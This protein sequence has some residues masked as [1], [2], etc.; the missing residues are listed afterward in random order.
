MTTAALLLGIALGG[1]LDG[2]LLHQILQWHH[3][4]GG[5][6]G[7]LRAQVVWDGLFHLA[8]YLIAVAGL[9][10]LWEARATLVEPGAGRRVWGAAALGFGL[11]HLVDGVVSHFVLGIHRTRL[12]VADPLPWDLGFLAFGA[13]WTWVGWRLLRGPGQGGGARPAVALA[14]AVLLAAPVA[15]LPPPAP[16]APPEGW[17]LPIGCFAGG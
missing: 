12:D 6:D 7:D 5:P 10:L 11:W 1:F 13:A 3:L 9:A 4:I 8:H 16:L 2:I 14:L 15:A 17:T